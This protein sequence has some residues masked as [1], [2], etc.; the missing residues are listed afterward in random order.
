MQIRCPLN[1][2]M[3][4]PY[5]SCVYRR[6]VQR[7]HYQPVDLVPLNEIALMF[8]FQDQYPPI[9]LPSASFFQ[10]LLVSASPYSTVRLS[11]NRC[12]RVSFTSDNS[13]FQTEPLFNL[14]AFSIGMSFTL[15]TY[16]CKSFTYI[17]L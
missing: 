6:T 8:L 7:R 4:P 16:V 1:S 2:S 9:E 3:Y 5:F 14:S 10:R 11:E 12:M 17:L 15:V 13:K